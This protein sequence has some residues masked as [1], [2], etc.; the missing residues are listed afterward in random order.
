MKKI[1]SAIMLV[2]L[3]ITMSCAAFAA[4][5][6][7]LN[8]NESAMLGWIRAEYETAQP[9][10]YVKLPTEFEAA[11]DAYFRIDGIDITEAQFAAAETQLNALKAYLKANL[12]VKD[13]VTTLEIKD[14][15]TEVYDGL[16]AIYEK[17][18]E[19]IDAS[20]VITND[21]YVTGKIVVQSNTVKD[22]IITVDKGIEVSSGVNMTVV[23]IA[24]AAVIV[25]LAAVAFVLTKKKEK[26]NA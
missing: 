20:I 13:G 1:L 26:V 16:L 24:S 21:R 18:A 15:S 19:A 14:V 9:G 17:M 8:A 5:D 7:G 3:L 2:A 4:G 10:V 25:A 22:A 6:A 12:T 23:I 11:A